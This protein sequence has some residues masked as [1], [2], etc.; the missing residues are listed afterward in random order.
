MIANDVIVYERRDLATDGMKAVWNNVYVREQS[1]LI[2]L[3]YIPP[4]ELAC[5][6][7]TAIFVALFSSIVQVL[8]QMYS[9]I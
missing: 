4:Q 6:V 3:I 2:G 9:V 7:C 8:Q 1:F 5:D